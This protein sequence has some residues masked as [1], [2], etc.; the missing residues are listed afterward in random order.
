MR[1]TGPIQ[2]VLRVIRIMRVVHPDPIRVPRKIVLCDPGTS[3]L[4]AAAIKVTRDR[5]GILL[6][7]TLF[8]CLHPLNGVPL[9][10][11]SDAASILKDHHHSNGP[12]CQEGCHDPHWPLLQ[13]RPIGWVI[14]C[15]VPIVHCVEATSR[16]Q[17]P[18]F[19]FISMVPDRLVQRI[20]LGGSIWLELRRWCRWHVHVGRSTS[21]A[22]CAARHATIARR[23]CQQML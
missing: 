14:L 8:S 10:L 16:Q 20:L 18:M 22:H 4:G 2:M 11:D 3:A 7:L 5:V 12:E 17:S 6:P 19:P 23:A 9:G 21:Q 1:V 15:E 13:P